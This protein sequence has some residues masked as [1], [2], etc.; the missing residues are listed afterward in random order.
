MALTV[1]N[2]GTQY[3][4][5]GVT[6]DPSVLAPL[7]RRY[8][9]VGA[10]WIGFDDSF[11]DPVIVRSYYDPTADPKVSLVHTARPAVFIGYLQFMQLS[12][13]TMAIPPSVYGGRLADRQPYV[14]G[15][16]YRFIDF[17]GPSDAKLRNITDPFY[18]FNALLVN[19]N[20][21]QTSDFYNYP[22]ENGSLCAPGDLGTGQSMVASLA[23][24]ISPGLVTPALITPYL[25][26]DNLLVIYHPSATD[27]AAAEPYRIALTQLETAPLPDATSD[28]PPLQGLDETGVAAQALGEY[29]LLTLPDDEDFGDTLVIST[30]PGTN[31]ATDIYVHLLSDYDTAGLTYN[32][33]REALWRIREFQLEEGLVDSSMQLDEPAGRGMKGLWTPPYR[34][35]TSEYALELRYWTLAVARRER[36]L[37]SSPSRVFLSGVTWTAL[38]QFDEDT[39]QL[40]FSAIGEPQPVASANVLPGLNSYTAARNSPRAPGQ[41]IDVSNFTKAAMRRDNF[42]AGTKVRFVD[43]SGT[44]LS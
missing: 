8:F 7:G 19:G 33:G 14:Y 39:G 35:S 10:H 24:E 29:V 32:A 9:R 21:T 34:L 31:G 28:P 1:S 12:F 17:M 5:S 40:T 30:Q 44:E 27:L 22:L 16:D 20:L 18:P 2:D 11:A 13:R 38:F 23:G 6:R 43:A 26:N 36:A 42:A 4:L 25:T 15:D 41:L 37:R 3:L